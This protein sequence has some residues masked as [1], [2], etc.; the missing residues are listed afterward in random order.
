L[1]PLA[2][3]A[4]NAR[5]IAPVSSLNGSNSQLPSDGKEEKTAGD[6]IAESEHQMGIF[7]IVVSVPLNVRMGFCVL[8]PLIPGS[9]M[10]L[11]L[12]P[13]SFMVVMRVVPLFSV[14]AFSVSMMA[15]V[16]GTSFVVTVAVGIVA[17]VIV[18]VT[19]GIVASVI[20]TVTVGIVASFIIPVIPVIGMSFP[21]SMMLV[22][23]RPVSPPLS[24][25]VFP[26]IGKR[27]TGAAKDCSDNNAEDMRR[28]HWLSPNRSKKG[29][30]KHAIRNNLPSIA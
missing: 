8:V 18:T 17:S 5:A 29:I 2:H 7:A 4:P 28:F 21:V 23:L 30:A 27:N 14:G 24:R 11:V 26:I 20:V 12:I 1:S 3:P 22:G 6:R 10:A 15:M 13:V 9:P 25:L 19:V 16:I